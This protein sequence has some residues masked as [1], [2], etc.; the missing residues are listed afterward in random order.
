MCT[1]AREG[2][3]TQFKDMLDESGLSVWAQTKLLMQQVKVQGQENNDGNV[4]A[5]EAEH[6]LS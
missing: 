6:C 3:K 1:S 2:F 4:E 5:V